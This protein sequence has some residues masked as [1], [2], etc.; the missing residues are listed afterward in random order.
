MTDIDTGLNVWKM[1][2]NHAVDSSCATYDAPTPPGPRWTRAGLRAH[3]P[4]QPRG[5]V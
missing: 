3:D 4:M 5:G 2:S 1:S